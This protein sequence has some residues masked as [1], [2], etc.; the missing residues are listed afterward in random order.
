VLDLNQQTFSLSRCFGGLPIADK[1]LFDFPTFQN[2]HLAHGL[3]ET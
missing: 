3:L 2:H 1:Q